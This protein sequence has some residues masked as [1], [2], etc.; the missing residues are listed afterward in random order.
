MYAEMLSSGAEGDSLL[1]VKLL[2]LQDAYMVK[3]GDLEPWALCLCPR[4][5]SEV[6]DAGSKNEGRCCS[7]KKEGRHAGG[8]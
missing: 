8:G 5:V 3:V 6:D 1:D 4:G 7:E 2:D